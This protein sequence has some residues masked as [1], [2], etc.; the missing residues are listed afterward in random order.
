MKCLCLL[1][2][3]KYLE[4]NKNALFEVGRKK[5]RTCPPPRVQRH[6][7]WQGFGSG[8][9]CAPS[10]AHTT[11]LP[12]AEHPAATPSLK[13]R[14]RE[15]KKSKIEGERKL[16]PG[17]ALGCSIFIWPGCGSAALPSP[18]RCAAS[19]SAPRGTAE[20]LIR[21]QAGLC[22]GMGV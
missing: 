5:D 3:H 17:V 8:S 7:S 15:R 13:G 2:R 21:P 12:R 11:L 20:E 22:V 9:P 16:L 18:C 1:Q 19:P 6:S 4:N 14:C 10:R